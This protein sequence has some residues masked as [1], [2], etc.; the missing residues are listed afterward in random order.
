MNTTTTPAQ[1][2]TRKQYMNKEVSHA[3]YYGQFVTRETRAFVAQTIGLDRVKASVDPHLN[4]IPLK[5]WDDYRG[6][7]EQ[8]AA[9][10]VAGD[11]PTLSGWVCIAKACARMMKA[12]DDA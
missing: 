9:L 6:T 10:R 7:A 1:I 8:A 2:K 4:D 3:E 5:K 12:E 11:S